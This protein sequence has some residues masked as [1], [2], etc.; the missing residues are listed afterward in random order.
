MA[1]RA[2]LTIDI[3][4]YWH[5]GTGQGLGGHLDAVTH[6]GTDKLPALPGRTVKGLL[7]DAVYRW[8]RFGAYAKTPFAGVKPSI[9]ECLFGPPSDREAEE[10]TAPADRRREGLLRCQSAQMSLSQDD[11]DYLRTQ[12][13][14]V[15]GLYRSHFSTAI[16][17]NGT[18]KKNSLRG[19]EVVVP[20]VLQAELEALDDTHPLALAWIEIVSPALHLVRAVGAHRSRGLGRAVLSLEAAP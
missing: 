4:S 3:R 2:H 13:E 14:L 19:I 15:A 6:R 16:E 12:P 7:R 11:R 5:P 17:A 10:S 20:L 8:E 18:A 9:T 1:N